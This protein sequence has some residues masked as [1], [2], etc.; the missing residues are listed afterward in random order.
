MKHVIDF[1]IPYYACNK[2]KKKI[3]S[4]PHIQNDV[5]HNQ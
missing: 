3:Q 4:P 5:F 1:I 2:S